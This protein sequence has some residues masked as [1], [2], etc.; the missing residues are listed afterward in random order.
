MRRPPIKRSTSTR[1]CADGAFDLALGR[2]ADA[3]SRFV[4]ARAHYLAGS[5]PGLVLLTEGYLAILRQIGGE[6]AGQSE[7][8]DQV[9]ARISAGEFKDA[10]AWIAQ[11][12]AALEVF[13]TAP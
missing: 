9:C 4:L 8:L 2:R 6:E 11:L 1:P 12:R 10:G 7:S 5:A 13:A 3:L